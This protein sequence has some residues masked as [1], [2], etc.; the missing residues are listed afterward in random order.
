MK[1]C[2]IFLF[3]YFGIAVAIFYALV[4][5]S[6]LITNEYTETNCF[7][8][9]ILYPNELPNQTDLGLW[10]PCKCGRDCESLTTC[11]KIIT[12]IDSNIKLLKQYT[13]PDLNPSGDCTFKLDNC[14]NGFLAMLQNLIDT[15][16]N[17]EYYENL[18]H[19]NNSFKCYTNSLQNEFYLYNSIPNYNIHL[20]SFIL[21]LSI[22]SCIVYFSYIIYYNCNKKKKDDKI[23]VFD[24]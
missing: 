3:I 4:I 18:L 11:T 10:K 20:G 8:Y 19:H 22:F 12:Y 16:K 24:N 15:K 1:F 21:G 23:L 5:K 6:I 17:A 7:V 13:V 2:P 14:D 9:N